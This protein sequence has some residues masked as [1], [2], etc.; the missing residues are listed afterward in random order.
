MSRVVTT[1]FAREEDTERILEIN[2]LEYGP[3]DILATRE[4]FVWRHSQNPAG[5]AIIPVI[6]NPKNQ[7]VGYIWIVPIRAR[8]KGKD[9]SVAM[10]SNLVIHPEYRKGVGYAR[11]MRCFNSVFRKDEIPL[12][13][14]FIS[15]E[16]Y[17]RQVIRHPERVATIP[18]LVK[19]YNSQ[20]VIDS[21]VQ[22]PLKKNA[23]KLASR[24]SS[25]F[26]F[27]KKR[28][29]RDHTIAVKRYEDFD[30]RFDEFWQ[31][32]QDYH[33]ASVI[34]DRSFLS[35]RFAH[36]SGR[37]Y[38]ILAAESEDRLCG[39]AVL[40]CATVRGIE[41]GIVA[42]L[43]VTDDRSG[44]NAGHSLLDEAESWFREHGMA[45]SFAL[46]SPGSKQYRL[47]WR[48]GY[49]RLP[50]FLS[51]RAFRFGVYLHTEQRQDLRS[52]TA[53]DWFVTVADYESY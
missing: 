20:E 13:Y 43:M 10:G 50:E 8:I 49:I 16:A 23:M 53:K 34:R 31:K 11:L 30:S 6:R 35:W 14:S 36:V 7:V 12:H 15:E 41:A 27:S 48:A 42:D 26:L 9:C 38:V 46:I 19:I 33:T 39:Y 44:R 22:G 18:T 40:R 5:K 25:P 17:Q 1:D 3:Q 2:R 29:K 28:K 45:S 21:Y 24:V 32:I 51:P 37:E 47:L 52:L 4:D